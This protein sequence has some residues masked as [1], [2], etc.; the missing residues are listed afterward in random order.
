MKVMIIGGTGH[1]GLPFGLV[2]ADQG[3][4]VMA[5]DRDEEKVGLVNAGEMP[6]MESGA[7]EL[8]TKVLST[9]GFA[10]TADPSCLACA[11]C[12]VVVI[13]T[14]V[15]EYLNPDPGA[16]VR[17]LSDLSSYFR[18]GQLVILRSTVFPGVTRKVEGWF[19]EH[20]P[21]IAVAC[22]PERIAEG[23]ALE[24]ITELP[25]LVGARSVEVSDRVVEF[26]D[27]IG[28][29]SIRV[30][31]EE[32][33]LAKVFTNSWRYIKFAAANQFW[34]MANEFDVDFERV[35]VA[36]TTDYP[37]AA[38]M[39]GA[40]FAAGPC[41]FKDTMQLSAF[42]G[43]TFALGNAAVMVNEGLPL[44]LIERLEDRFQLSDMTV[45]I[46]GMAFKGDTDDNRSSLSYKLRKLLMFRAKE[47]LCSDPYVKDQ[48][49][50]AEKR[51]LD[52]SDLI[53]VATP[54]EIYRSL[55]CDQPLIDIW[56]IYGNGVLI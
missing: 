18:P 53:I 12:V 4:Q 47:V 50:V 52:E 16:V 55:V 34:M 44:Y 40:G 13:G 27:S 24:E 14:P 35:R 31:P 41:L 11:E 36:I 3:H 39:P 5:F 7:Q 21:G 29:R 37:R 46:L 43:N 51:V 25:Q 56:N 32:A 42:T 23:F 2:L 45:G 1:V 26:F 28:V 49:L 19:A 15:D 30:E 6:F 10:A 17:A 8:L 22:C 38:D 33:E 9:P 20:H 48:R 54:H